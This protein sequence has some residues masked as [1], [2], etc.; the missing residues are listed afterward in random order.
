MLAPFLAMKS[1]QRVCATSAFIGYSAILTA[2]YSKLFSSNDREEIMSDGG[3]L[4][5][6]QFGAVTTL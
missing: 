1:G 3:D 4:V 5:R 6:K 2:G